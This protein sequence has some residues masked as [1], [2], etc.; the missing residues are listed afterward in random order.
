MVSRRTRL[1]VVTIVG[2]AILAAGALAVSIAG[3]KFDSIPTGDTKTFLEQTA[4]EL[5]VENGAEVP[6]TADVVLT[7]REDSQKVV[8]GDELGSENEPVYLVQMEGKFAANAVPLPAGAEAPTGTSLWF[9]VDA[10]TLQRLDWGL[11]QQPGDLSQLGEVSQ[12]TPIP[13]DSSTPSPTVG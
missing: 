11:A 3:T 5:A 1:V 8:G 7:G 9:L 13:P 10:P 12:I 4:G 2:A 6:A